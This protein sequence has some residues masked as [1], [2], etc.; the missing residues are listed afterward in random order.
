MPCKAV[1]KAGLPH[2]CEDPGILPLERVKTALP[3]FKHIRGSTLGLFI[4]WI[5]KDLYGVPGGMFSEDNVNEVF[6]LVA[7]KAEDP[8]W[9]DTVLRKHCG[10]QGNI[11]VEKEGAPYGPQIAL[12]R[13]GVPLNLTDGKRTSREVL[14]SMRKSWNEVLEDASD[15]REMLCSLASS[16]TQSR[17][18]FVGIWLLPFFEMVPADEK[19]VTRV[20]KRAE[21]GTILSRE[22]LNCFTAFGL[23][24]FLEALR[25]EALRTIQVIAGAEVLPPHRSITHWSGKLCGVLGRLA[26]EY[27][28]FHF[29]CSS[30]CDAN[31]QDLAILAKH[32]PNISV[33]GYWWHSLYPFFIRKSIEARLDIVPANKI[34]G[35]FSDAYHAE[36][37][38]PKLKMVK[39]IFEEVL[40][41][42][43]E[44]GW[45]N[46]DIALSLGRQV[47]YDNPARIYNMQEMSL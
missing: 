21:S 25:K 7:K 39:A 28:D 2:E 34:V 24:C 20:I 8:S 6:E 27:E 12:G 33:A 32:V 22:D 42:R 45:Y 5:L 16:C 19:S 11:T 41:E 15:Y 9:R 17:V 31:I 38:Y 37:C 14:E 40:V 4:R 46:E 44:K 13:E 36:W 43:V 26:G 10:I 30:A 35:F 1:S 23:R 29:D 47:F 18:K 3:Y